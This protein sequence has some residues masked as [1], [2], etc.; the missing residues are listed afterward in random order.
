MEQLQEVAQSIFGETNEL[1]STPFTPRTNGMVERFN[2]KIQDNV[3][4]IFKTQSYK[5]LEEL[6]NRY[7]L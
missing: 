6:I 1:S 4:N 2:R 5:E 3:L 7:V